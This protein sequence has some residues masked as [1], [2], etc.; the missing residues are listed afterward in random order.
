MHNFTWQNA[1]KVALA[2]TQILEKQYRYIKQHLET[3]TKERKLNC[4]VY[5]ERYRFLK[6]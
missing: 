5:R 6:D 2:L 1:I 4:K 3:V